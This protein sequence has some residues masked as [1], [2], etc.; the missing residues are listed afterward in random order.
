MSTASPAVSEPLFLLA[1]VDPRCR[2]QRKGV[3]MVE[4]TDSTGQLDYAS[5]RAEAVGVLSRGAR[6]GQ[7][8]SVGA[9]DERLEPVDGAKVFT[10]ALA[11][12]AANIGHS[13]ADALAGRPG[14][15]DAEA[16]PAQACSIPVTSLQ[17]CQPN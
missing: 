15:G 4:P 1:P 5:L 3:T 11:G 8:T 12:A 6:L 16:G 2:L 14:S 10:L 9:G 13:E 17:S 7:S